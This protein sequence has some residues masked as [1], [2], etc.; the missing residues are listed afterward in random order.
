M[1]DRDLI[2][3]AANL[4][5]SAPKEWSDFLA[6]FKDYADTRRDQCVSSSPDALFVAQGRAQS[7]VALLRLFEDCLKAADQI[8][9]KRK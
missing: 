1:S 5:R 6:A 4:A 3:K 7:C 2:L 8:Q 9:E